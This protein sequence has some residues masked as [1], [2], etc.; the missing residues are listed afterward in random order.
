M[1]ILSSK[2]RCFLAFLWSIN[3][4][5]FIQANN[6]PIHTSKTQKLGTYKIS[7]VTVSGLSAGGFM[8][9]QVHVAFSS[10]VNGSAIFAG[11]PYFCA[12][13]NLYTAEYTCMVSF[14]FIIYFTCIDQPM[15]IENDDGN[16]RCV[17]IAEIHLNS[18]IFKSY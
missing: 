7:D 13:A 14:I 15:Y 6:L 1:F 11:G 10:V 17:H 5:Q 18:S 3:L 9:V 16:T 12:D 8:A 2:Y 4:I